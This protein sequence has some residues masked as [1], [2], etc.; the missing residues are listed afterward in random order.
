MTP[1]EEEI[2][3]LIG[4]N[5]MISQEE[6]AKKTH[7]SRSSV[8]VHITSLKR[9]GYILGRRYVVRTKPYVAVVGG[10]NIDI[11]GTPF[12]TFVPEDSN[13]GTVHT[14]FGGVG[15]NIAQ[16]LALLSLPVEMLTVL[17]NDDNAKKIEEHCHSVGI[18][19]N[20]AKRV[21]DLPT[22]TYLYVE[23]EK[24]KMVAAIADMSIMERFDVQYVK[25]KEE[26]LAK[27]QVIV[28]DTNPPEDA[29]LEILRTTKAPIIADAVSTTKAK[30]L[31]KG[32]SYLTGLKCNDLEA[33]TLTG[34]EIHD[35]ATAHQAA[36]RLV[37]LGVKNAFISLGSE[38]ACA[39]D[40]SG[41]LYLPPFPGKVVNTTGCGDAFTAG[42]VYAF[43][44][45]MSLKEALR[46][47]LATATFPLETESSVNSSLSESGMCK[48]AGLP[49]P[50]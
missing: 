8:A 14:S 45:G 12:S 32:L 7:M 3:A 23:N 37:Q 5:P 42:I 46:A 31:E 21:P 50:Q 40:K 18:G 4:E 20:Y 13:P 11:G 19:L 44:R 41:S 9:Q 43:Y 39:A 24:G 27:A 33:M 28:L 34:I 15:R 2:L 48:R 35:V 26:A 17:G 29:L 36:D 25:E 10:I 38:G 22:S 30:K 6:I 16:D 1:R 49:L 47:G